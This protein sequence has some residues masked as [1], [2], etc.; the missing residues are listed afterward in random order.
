[1]PLQVD[2]YHILC[3]KFISCRRRRCYVRCNLPPGPIS[4]P[5]HIYDMCVCIYLFIYGGIWFAVGLTVDHMER[6]DVGRMLV[7]GKR[8]RAELLLWQGPTV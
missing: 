5:L 8:T 2:F 1:M 4:T 3:Y 7:I 6:C